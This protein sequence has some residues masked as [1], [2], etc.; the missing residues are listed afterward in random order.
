M[1]SPQHW[2]QNALSDTAYD[3][4][5]DGTWCVTHHDCATIIWGGGQLVSTVT[6]DN[7]IFSLYILRLDTLNLLHIVL[8]LV[9][10]HIHMM[11]SLT[12][13]L[14]TLLFSVALRSLEA[15]CHRLRIHLHHQREIT[16]LHREGVKAHKYQ[17]MLYYVQRQRDI[18]QV[19]FIFC[20]IFLSKMLQRPPTTLPLKKSSRILLNKCYG[21][22]TSMEINLPIAFQ[23]WIPMVY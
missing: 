20:Q 15:Q 9:M 1:I 8:L 4:T 12:V 7:Q 18:N 23:K 17:H 11:I 13:S 22:T 3:T 10:T 5:L 16:N 21:C 14:P 6:L 2:A 19:Y